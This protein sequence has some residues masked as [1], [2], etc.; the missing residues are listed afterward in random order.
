MTWVIGGGFCCGQDAGYYYP[1]RNTTCSSHTD[2][3]DSGTL[4]ELVAL[5]SSCKA[6]HSAHVILFVFWNVAKALGK[7]ASAT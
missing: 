4:Q 2:T 3:E 5:R 7:Q 6:P 1:G